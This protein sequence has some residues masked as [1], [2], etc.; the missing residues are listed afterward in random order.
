MRKSEHDISVG[1]LIYSLTG[2]YDKKAEENMENRE[3][4]ENSAKF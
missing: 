3:N 2:W 1:G 4:R